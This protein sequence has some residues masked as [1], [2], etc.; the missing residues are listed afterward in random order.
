MADP[1]ETIASLRNIDPIRQAR[2]AV[3]MAW[4]AELKLETWY[5]TGELAEAAEEWLSDQGRRR[6]PELWEALFAIAPAEK[7]QKIEPRK[8]GRWLVRNTKNIAAGYCLCADASDASRLKYQLVSVG[9]G[10][11]NA[12]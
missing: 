10:S 5:R 8:L 2:A 9:G 11:A 1:V 12:G 4:A 6:Y 7:A 3:F